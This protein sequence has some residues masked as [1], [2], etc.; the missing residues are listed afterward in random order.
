[1]KHIPTTALRAF[2]VA[3]VLMA[4]KV[5]ADTAPTDGL[6]NYETPHVHPID[7][8]PDR[9][10]LLAVNT[11]AHTLEIFDVRGGTPVLVDS[12]AVGIDPVSVRARSNTEAW[13][14]N[15]VSDSISIVD[16]TLKAVVQTLTTSNE[17]ADVV[18]AGTPA[19]AFVSCSEVNRVE[20][21]DLANL[22]AAPTRLAI[23][24]EDPRHLAVSPDGRT[25]YAAIFESGNGTTAISGGGSVT[26]QNVVSRPEGPYA[27]QNPPPNRGNSFVPAINPA[28]PAPPRTAMIVRKNASNRWMDDNNRDWSIFVNG[29]LASLTGRV[30]NWDLTD[31]DVAVIDAQTLAISYQTRMMTTVMALGVNPATGRVTAIGTEAI[32]EVRFEPILN[33]IFV[34]VRAASF[35]GGGAADSDDLNPH[36]TYQ[37]AT[38]PA[39]QRQQ[40][41]GDPRGIAWRQN[42]QQAFITGM[43]SNNVV[44]IDPAG[45]RLGHFTVGQGPTG[46]VLDDSRGIGFV[47]N[48]F[49]GSISTVDLNAR[50]QTAVTAF[51][52]PTPA[53]I[54]E[55]RPFLYNTHLTSGLGQVS[56]ASCHVDARTDRLSWDLGNPAGTMDTV[57][58][59]DNNTGNTTGTTTVHPMKGP[60][61]T[62][63]LQDIMN[64]DRLHWRGDR[65]GLSTFNGAFTGLLGAERQLTSAEMAKFAAFLG[66]IHL[67][68]NPYRRI[69]NTRPASVTLPDGS[70]ATTASFNALRG[71][72]SRGNNCLQCHL[73]GDTRNDASNVELSQAF[74]APS[75]APFYDRLGFWPR[76]QNG[77]T[78]GFGFFHD[79]ADSIGGAA[80]T[81]T[82]ENQTDM[83]AE[84]LTLEGP[85][86]PLTGSERR[87]D[88]HAGVGQQITLRGTVTT[89]QRSR[90]DQL[91]AIANGSTHADLIVKGRV[92]GV[93]RGY[94]HVSGTTF[95]ADKQGET[96]TLNDL[97]ALAASGNPLTFTLV[98][99]GMANRLALDFNRNGVLDGDETTFTEDP[100]NLLRNGGFESGLTNWDGGGTFAATAT[101]HS[102][103]RSATIGEW[104]HIVQSATVTAGS[105]YQLSGFYFSQGSGQNLEAGISFWS[106]N[107][108]WVGDRVVSLAQ[109][110]GY[111]AFS[112]DV[113]AP[114]GAAVASVWVLAGG[115][116][117]ATVDQIV[118]KA[119]G[120]GDGQGGGG[121]NGGGGSQNLLDNGGFESGLTGWDRGNAVSLSTT[122]REGA[123]AA[124]IGDESFIVQGKGVNVGE[125][126]EL[127]GSYLSTG[128]SQRLEVG[129]SFWNAAGQWLED[130]TIVL[131][132]SASYR[133]FTVSATVPPTT[134]VVTVWV[135][136]GAGGQ[137][138][139][140]SL[141]LLR[142]GDGNSTNLFSN[143]GFESGGLAGW[144]TGGSASL[145]GGARTG[146]NAVRLGSE[147]FVVFNR[148]AAAGEVYR[149]GGFYRTEGTGTG[150]EAG[151]SFWGA[152]G[153]WLGDSK[154]TL[155]AASGYTAFEVLAQVPNGAT[156]ISAWVWSG[157][158]GVVITDD[159]DLRQ[160]AT[161]AQGQLAD[162]NA[163]SGSVGDLEITEGLF[164]SGAEK[165][166][167]VSFDFG[168]G[169]AYN[170]L[171]FGPVGDDGVEP[172][173][174]GLTSLILRTDGIFSGQ[175]VLN[176]RKIVLKGRFDAGGS[177]SAVYADG[178]RLELR[179]FENDGAIDLYGLFI[180]AAGVES[181]LRALRGGYSKAAP[182]PLAGVY[183]QLLPGSTAS[184]PT[185]YG[186]TAIA[187]TGIVK[188]VGRLSDGRL[189][190]HA[191][192]L[193]ARDEWSLFAIIATKPSVVLLGGELAFRDTGGVSDFD[194][195]LQI[196]GGGTG[197]GVSAS[198]V[199]AIG[200]RFAPV[201]GRPLIDGL[202]ATGG[203]AIAL[204]QDAAS[205]GED[206]WPV[207]WQAN[208]R[209][210]ATG[211]RRFAGVVNPRT[212][213]F[214]ATAID[215][216]TGFRVAV[217][218]V[219]FQRQGLVG[220]GYRGKTVSGSVILTPGKW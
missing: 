9:Q 195:K 194:G 71:Q 10:T 130:S 2:A 66:T 99:N 28:L 151:I 184:Q 209:I 127:R 109:V 118:F 129:L 132:N 12:V 24:G 88:T 204:F 50:R 103:A 48:K 152:D 122:A 187:P 74:I 133:D 53:V 189:F 167:A 37:V 154:T 97:L 182:A 80:R 18:F 6:V 137:I 143:G 30:A 135:W 69:D 175:G 142:T 11:A 70:T 72:N 148:A 56:C 14:V 208:N 198:F 217:E 211:T 49:D 8:T 215:L 112:K 25:V 108:T 75:F 27:G 157:T 192:Y 42:G 67:P 29:S 34:R 205:G 38:L 168:K 173:T 22:G 7:L 54:K 169:G 16:L 144:D 166:R 171:F 126:L 47:M 213:V 79:G 200:S 40:S 136:S 180:D 181:R 159:L 92:A 218:G 45:N 102:G 119:G 51:N 120:N 146:S 1:M 165:G 147:S 172:V 21:F 62:Q 13:V 58:R 77:S 94:L 95:Q 162:V 41:I 59:A 96:R 35:G 149:F 65:A 121:G 20:V 32:N 84:I 123:Q 60:M 160:N 216:A 63:T 155:T 176:G 15:H 153:S 93:K 76:S 78:S 219:V 188:T 33:G 82:A 170:G 104:S 141:Q 196:A 199:T 83:L 4:G 150:N 89:A 68:P 193:S 163:R 207:L 31:R 116:G 5:L 86:G 212:G 206:Y 185:G 17:P 106:S 124:R 140:D 57:L 91:I 139:V 26:A 183:T 19:R 131:S 73:N 111:T 138:T 220:G 177:H 214:T 117:G 158:N 161:T 178:S 115:G 134:T 174:G 52:D 210:V 190:S 90:V 55:G 46:I 43:G 39:D 3:A 110:S 44:I 128:N 36:L 197:A 85:G 191:G 202:T 105:N 107:G 179:L 203:E 23:G 81:T 125:N 101:P 61:L 201:A 87:Q 156:S 164:T 186:V 98:A 145:V 114:S 64:Y 100:N 113:T